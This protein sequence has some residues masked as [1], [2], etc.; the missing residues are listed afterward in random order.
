VKPEAKR[1][2]PWED[3]SRNPE[4]AGASTSSSAKIR[5]MNHKDYKT[6]KVKIAVSALSVE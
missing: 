2:V 4:D 5:V 1:E 6:W 3:K